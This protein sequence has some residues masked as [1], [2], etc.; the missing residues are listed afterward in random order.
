MLLPIQRHTTVV[1]GPLAF[2]M[3]RAAAARA[4]HSG[5]Q[6]FNL[7]QVAARLAGG[8]WHLVTADTLEPA[9]RQALAEGGFQ[10]IEHVRTLP[11][12]TRA[13]AR[14]LRKAWH[15]DIDVTERARRDG[16]RVEDLALIE[17]R[18]RK[19]LPPNAAFP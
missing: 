17:A 5:L 19:A 15:A 4:N 10:E 2:G 12:M 6:I 16:R 1:Q 11:G 7:S 13:V 3:R 14:T 9:I 8:F 18:L